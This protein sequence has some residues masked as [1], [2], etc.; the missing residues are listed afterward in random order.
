MKKRT[1]P[2]VRVI[3]KS[4]E[5]NDLIDVLYQGMTTVREE[6]AQLNDMFIKLLAEI[7]IE[8]KKLEE[9]ILRNN[10]V[11]VLIKICSPANTRS[12]LYLG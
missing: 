9:I 8:N 4:S 12:G 11:M 1:K 10:G 2:T 7:H 3:R 6:L 5:I